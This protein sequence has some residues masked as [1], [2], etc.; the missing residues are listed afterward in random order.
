MM[1]YVFAAKNGGIM[2][3]ITSDNGVHILFITTKKLFILHSFSKQIK[4]FLTKIITY[5]KYI[6]NV[7]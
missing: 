1:T 6:A 7:S 2:I 3:S 5:L 4:G